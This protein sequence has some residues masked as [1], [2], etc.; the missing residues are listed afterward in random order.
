MEINELCKPTCINE[1][2]QRGPGAAALSETAGPLTKGQNA[3]PQVSSE[4]DL[5]PKQG[6]K[7]EAARERQSVN[8]KEL[9]GE[10]KC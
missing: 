3:F 5:D 1:G 7:E 2:A 6:K 4:M 9:Q 10:S 8:P